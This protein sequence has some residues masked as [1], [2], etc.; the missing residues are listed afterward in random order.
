M[1]VSVLGVE[2]VQMDKR[3]VR[4]GLAVGA[5]AVVVAAVVAAVL[6][7]LFAFAISVYMRDFVF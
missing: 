1:D 7:G 6:Y 4:H 2:G 5:L 3:R